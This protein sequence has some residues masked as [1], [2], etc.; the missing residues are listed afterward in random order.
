MRVH[1]L[2]AAEYASG[3]FRPTD[4]AMIVVEVQFEGPAISEATD[5][6]ITQLVSY[7]KRNGQVLGDD[8]TIALDATTYTV[9]AT[10]P[11]DG[12]LDPKY[13][14]HFAAEARQ[15]L[16]N[17]GFGQ[18]DI[19]PRGVQIYDV[20]LCTCEHH[21]HFIL[22]T[23]HIKDTSCFCCGDCFESI[24]LYRIP[25]LAGANT[26]Q[27]NSEK[28]SHWAGTYKTC[29]LL[30]M[31]SGI[32]EAFAQRQMQQFDSKLSKCGIEICRVLGVATGIPTYYYLHRYINNPRQKMERERRCPSCA[33]EWL[34]AERHHIF[35]FKCDAC[36]LLSNMAP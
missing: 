25:Y 34:L 33:G 12:A 1:R 11:E 36:R 9:F 22:F 29:D 8:Y 13:D 16:A 5:G 32:G 19:T 10:L 27:C 15:K 35:D 28:L 4:H 20:D 14:L 17:A 6:A 31:D 21:T 7:W 3:L 23:T 30:Y 18:P 2:V 24:P 26:E